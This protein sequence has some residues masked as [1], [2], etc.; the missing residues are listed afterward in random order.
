MKTATAAAA[1][2]SG[3]PWFLIRK[4]LTVFCL[5]QQHFSTL[6]VNIRRNR[7]VGPL[8]PLSEMKP[9]QDFACSR[10]KIT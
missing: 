7:R 3:Q 2:P 4:I 8:I 5:P 6:F 10:R 1:D 9:F